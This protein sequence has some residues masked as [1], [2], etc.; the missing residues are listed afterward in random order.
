MPIDRPNTKHQLLS[1]SAKLF[2]PF[3]WFAPVI[4]RVKILYQKCWLYDFNWHDL[5]PPTIEEEWIEVKK[6]L[7]QLEQI[8]IPR[9]ASNYNSNVQLHGFSDASEEAYAAVVYLRSVDYNNEV[10]VTLLAAKTKV[11]PVRQNSIPRLELKAAELLAKLMKQVAGPLK[12]FNIERYA[13]TDSTIVLQWLSGHPCKWDTYVANRTSL[14]LDVLPRKHWS[15]VT[16]K[17]NPADCASRG[18]SPSDLVNH[19]LWWTG[20]DSSTWNREVPDYNNS[21]DTLEVRKRYKTLNITV[22][23]PVTTNVIEKQIIKQRSSLIAQL[24]LSRI[25]GS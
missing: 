22:S 23:L 21:E 5:L 18:I 11:A 6:T 10:H 4:V 20:P 25:D 19:P 16:S 8:K 3:G 2:D 1:D 14:I 12:R 15:H 13:W 17:N 9:W 7:H 24:N